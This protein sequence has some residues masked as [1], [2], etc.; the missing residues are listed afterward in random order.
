MWSDRDL[1]RGGL[2]PLSREKKL[3]SFL[4][5]SVAYGCGGLLST[6][7][8][9]GGRQAALEHKLL[10][11]YHKTCSSGPS[12]TLHLLHQYLTTCHAL[13]YYG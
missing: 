4:P 6:L 10:D 3:V 1:H 13:P 8:G 12:D 7:R 9:R 5:A 2:S 11:E